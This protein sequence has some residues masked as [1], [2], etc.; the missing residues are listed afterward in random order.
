MS[1]WL[2]ERG[3]GMEATGGRCRL[4]GDATVVCSDVEA[5]LDHSRGSNTLSGQLAS[6]VA[7]DL[8]RRWAHG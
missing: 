3:T 1:E 4:T 5:T 6:T 8:P 2:D 7:T